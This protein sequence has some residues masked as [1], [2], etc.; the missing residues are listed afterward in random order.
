MLVPFP[1]LWNTITG[2]ADDDR[3]PAIQLFGRRFFKDQSIPEFLIEFLLVA[4]SAKRVGN[5]AIPDDQA[6]PDTTLLC[7][8][9][10]GVPLEYAPKARLN[11]KLFAFLGASKLETRH[12]SHREHYKD[13]LDGLRQRIQADDKDD[14]L[15]TLE[16]LFLGFQGVGGQRTWCAQSFLPIAR[17]MCACETIWRGTDA[18]RNNVDA[19]SHA[20]RYFDHRQLV[21]LARG[22]EVLYLQLCNALRRNSCE[23]DGWVQDVGLHFSEMECKPE[24][25]HGILSDGLQR[26]VHGCPPAIDELARLI[27]SG[28]EAQT[29][30][31][32]DMVRNGPRYAECAW[33]PEES[34]PEGYLFAVELARVSCAAVDPL[35]RLSLMETACAMQVL[36]SLCAQSA[37]HATQGPAA[38]VGPL[39]FVWAVS[40]P[41]GRLQASTQVSRRTVETLKR[42]ISSAI[43]NP[44]IVDNVRDYWPDVERRLFKEAD[45]KYGHGLFLGLAKRLGL[46]A[47]RRGQGARFVL[48]DRLLRF[49]VMALIRPGER[50]TF[51]TFKKMAFAHYGLAFDKARLADACRWNGDTRLQAFEGEPDG[52]LAEMLEAGGFLV[53]LSDA[54]S[55]VRNPFGELRKDQ[56]HEIPCQQHVVTHPQ[57]S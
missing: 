47:P 3:N 25:L 35:E 54:C 43:R 29:S 9:P 48:N 11:L 46:M 42:M 41:E 52:W 50:V 13:L 6:L 22:G 18:D 45:E 5:R 51:D 53:R 24:A 55:Q 56:S 15:R 44:E 21:F 4:S 36:R 14:V 34:W 33:C 32:T 49:L 1:K 27:D 8:W 31:A 23:I 16:N 20:Q 39:G 40:D 12:E 2:Q 26:A 10:N 17:C 38:K 37:R 30:E 57:A 7:D 28:V 19:W